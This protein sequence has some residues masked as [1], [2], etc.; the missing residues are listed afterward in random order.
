MGEQTGI[1]WT[2][3]TWNPW[4]GCLKISPGC[5]NCYM[6]REKEHYGQDPFTVVRAKTVF[7][8]PLKWKSGRV[9]TCSWSDFFIERA[10]PWREEAWGIIR[11]TPHLT[12]QILTKRP[13]RVL[14]HL[15]S[16]WGSGWDHVWLGVSAENQPYADERI[17]ELIKIPAAVRFVS[18]EPLLDEI[19]LKT[20]WSP[21]LSWVIVG[22]ESG[23]GAR[24][25]DIHWI[26]SL[27]IQCECAR[28][29]LFVKQFGARPNSGGIP[30]KVS[31]AGTDPAEWPEYLRIQE[32]PK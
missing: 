27:R 10:D 9:F 16:D 30:I 13:E 7:N 28:L 5:K 26:D 29:P 11:R 25:C 31:H 21:Y 6:Y 20:H 8:A 15:P 19:I 24:P 18:A 17:S 14:A 32:F 4:H 3:H 22:G 1:S 23:P 12:Y 2:D